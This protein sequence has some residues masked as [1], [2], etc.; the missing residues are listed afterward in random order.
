METV[1]LTIDNRQ[2]EAEKDATVLAA[3]QRA[4]IYIPALCSHPDLKP[5][6]FSLPDLACRLCL[7]EIEGLADLTLS[8]I[9]VV[10]EG[11]HVSTHT[12]EVQEARRESLKRILVEHPH[13]CLTCERAQICKPTDVCISN[14]SV[15]ERCVACPKNGRC[16]FQRIVQYIGL[17]EAKVPFEPKGLPRGK[18]E[19]LF[20]RDYNLCILCGRCV[21]VCNDVVGVG[22]LKFVCEDGRCRVAPACGESMAEAGCKFCGACVEV[23]P[24]AALIDTGERWTPFPDREAALV[25]CRNACPAGIDVPR[26]VHLIVEGR[27]ADAV[28][29]IKE[30]VPFPS[31]LGHVCTHPCEE[32]CRRGEL[33]EPVAIKQL[34]RFA[35]EHSKGTG[36]RKPR[37]APSTGKKVAVVGSGP[38]GLSAAYYLASLGH[39]VTVFEALPFLGGMMR[40]GIPRYRLPMEVLDAEIEEIVEKSGVAVRTNA[41]IESLD[42]LFDQGYQAIFLALGAHEDIGLRIKGED[43]PSVLKCL[44]FLREVNLGCEVDVGEK[45][46][47]IGGGNAAIDASRTALRLGAREVTILYRRGKAEMPADKEEVEEALEEGVKIKFRVGPSSI[48]TADGRVKLEC[49]RMKLGRPDASGRRH[50]EPIPG[51][52]FS[53]DFD[54]VIVAIGQAPSVPPGFGSRLNRHGTIRVDPDTLATSREGVFAGGDVVLGPSSVVEVAAMGRRAAI[55]IDRY[56]GGDGKIEESAIQIPKGEM[57]LGRDEDFASWPRARAEPLLL[58]ERLSDFAEV[59]ACLDKE[60]AVREARRCLRCDLR[61]QISKVEWP[62]EETGSGSE[63]T[64]GL[65]V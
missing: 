37:I 34:K 54:T 29:V 43:A 5:L 12:S 22:A 8:C 51:R 19:P 20:D 58:E 47:V 31:I 63:G 21:S 30:K 50:P 49:V 52:E 3:A 59:E 55:S 48:S 44:P 28:S 14:V 61:L 65:N 18:E 33:N 4:G 17:G 26:Y 62:P 36:E 15:A 6:A 56:L 57:W 11:M 40:V 7:V 32:A 53:M 64:R 13:A 39:S 23:C 42:W 2:V 10:E 60:E 38:A 41:R 35:V 45:V 9:T 27:F 24:T 16:E 46:A 25:P 1:T